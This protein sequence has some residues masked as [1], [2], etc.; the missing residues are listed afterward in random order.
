[1]SFSKDYHEIFDI[2]TIRKPETDIQCRSKEKEVSLS[3]DDREKKDFET[4]ELK[5]RTGKLSIFGVRY[6][7]SLSQRGH[8]LSL[9]TDYKERSDL[10]TIRTL[11]TKI[12]RRKKVMVS[13]SN[14]YQE[15]LDIETIRTPESV[16][17]GRRKDDK[18]DGKD[19]Q[20]IKDLETMELKPG[21]GKLS[22]FGA[23][24][25]VTV[26]MLDC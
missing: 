8:L 17:H 15:I 1:M 26:T 3:E 4:M 22:I 10:V 5:Q 18:D 11:D 23:S 7:V 20:E 25:N 2:E 16:I 19:D 12:D 6:N 13:L 9:D 21:T 14:E 24:Y